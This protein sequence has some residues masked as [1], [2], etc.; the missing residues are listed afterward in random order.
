MSDEPFSQQQPSA[1]EPPASDALKAG[2]SQPPA[3]HSSP[4]SKPNMNMVESNYKG[5]GERR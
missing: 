1:P 4:F 2:G 5:D 3:S